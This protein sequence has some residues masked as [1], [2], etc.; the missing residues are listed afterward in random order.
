MQALICREKGFPGARQQNEL[1]W[2]LLG[3]YLRNF[4]WEN[5]CGNAKNMEKWLLEFTIKP[6]CCK[7][8]FYHLWLYILQ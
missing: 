7:Q 8:S 6:S 3:R 1:I 5:L 2:V 4:G